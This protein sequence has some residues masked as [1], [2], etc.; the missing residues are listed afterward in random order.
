MN[1]N[2]TGPGVD[3]YLEGPAR[4]APGFD[5]LHRMMS[6]LLAE[7][8]LKDGRASVIGAG[9]G[10]KGDGQHASRSVIQLRRPVG[11]YAPP[12]QM[13]NEPIPIR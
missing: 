9:D 12:C 7:R 8:M 6:Y 5:G 4:H 10:D 3:C 2:S 13:D 1:S 11:G